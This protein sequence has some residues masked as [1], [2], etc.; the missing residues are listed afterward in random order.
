MTVNEPSTK[1]VETGWP[2]SDRRVVNGSANLLRHYA[3][4]PHRLLRYW[5]RR[6]GLWGAFLTDDRSVPLMGHSR[7]SGRGFWRL[8]LGATFVALARGRS[9]TPVSI[10]II[11]YLP[12]GFRSWSWR[13]LSVARSAV[14]LRGAFGVPRSRLPVWSS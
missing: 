3:Q 6:A 8:P 10:A 9:L 4:V 11:A 7:A 5:L 12:R 1:A 2:G 13:G 14:P